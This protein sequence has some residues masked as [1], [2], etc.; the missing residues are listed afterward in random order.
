[1]AT[2]LL[3][4]LVPVAAGFAALALRKNETAGLPL[5]LLAGAANLGLAAWVLFK[6][7]SCVLP[8]ELHGFA[9]AFEARGS[10]VYLLLAALLFLPTAAYAALHFKGRPGGGLFSL[11]LYVSLSMVNGALL[12]DHL[13]LLLFFWEGLLCTLLGM[14]LTADPE[15]PGAVTKGFALSGTSDLLLMLGVA[16][17][18]HAGGTGGVHEMSG[19]DARGL[20]AL[21]CACLLAGSLGKAGCF[22]FHSW[23]PDAAQDAPAPFAAAFPNALYRILGGYLAVRVLQFYALP[24]ASAFRTALIVIGLVTLWMGSAFSL[25]QT[26]ARRGLAHLG[27]AQAGT[28]AL[29]L[30]AGVG[31]FGAALQIGVSGLGIAGLRM[32]ADASK[33]RAGRIAAVPLAV[34]LAV[35]PLLDG[36]SGSVSTLAALGARGVPPLLLALAG[37]LLVALALFRLVR[38]LSFA[39]NAALLPPKASQALRGLEDRGLLDPYRWLMGFTGGLAWASR[40]IEDGVTWIYDVALPVATKFVGNRLSRFD[41]G[42]LSRYLTLAV[43]GMLAV[44]AIFAIVLL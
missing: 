37:L 19:L 40:R 42:S 2:L 5:A 21:G 36:R 12:A 15:K 11:C 8:I 44:G 9:F 38:S 28:L 31:P 1:M 16:A 25:A 43:V 18:A 35:Y 26:D 41:N 22:P 17:I 4:L 7:L 23:I 34:L 39:K 30:G 6:G 33:H 13:G 32:A 10:A 3:L 14:L 29:A 24:A 20:G 27:I